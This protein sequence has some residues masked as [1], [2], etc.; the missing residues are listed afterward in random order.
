MR[1]EVYKWLLER[2]HPI[3]Y[4]GNW[5]RDRGDEFPED[6][7]S[8]N[9]GD[10]EEPTAKEND[11]FRRPP[12][13]IGPCVAMLRTCRQIYHEAVGVLY[14]SNTILV[15]AEPQ[16]HKKTMS[17]IKTAERLMHLLGSQLVLVR[18]I[19][20]DVS[21]LCPREC[22]EDEPGSQGA[23]IDILPI[24]R[25]LWSRPDTKAQ[26]RFTRSERHLDPR[27][28]PYTY[29]Q[30]NLVHD[31][32]VHLLEDVVRAVGTDDALSIKRY[33]RFE[34]LLSNIWLGRELRHGW[35][36]YQSSSRDGKYYGEDGSVEVSFTIHKNHSD[37]YERLQ[38]DISAIIPCSS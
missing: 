13:A 36:V 20:I 22:E 17:Q 37:S 16:R 1:N 38:W 7:L 15:S 8:E 21:P 25:M 34:S 24:V 29:Y 35:V 11:Q 2:D 30:D 3:I 6:F 9:E 14:R 10:D 32:N 31:L 28:H 26:V 27:L 23:Q 18:D 5:K 4:T 19:A 33:G 12:H